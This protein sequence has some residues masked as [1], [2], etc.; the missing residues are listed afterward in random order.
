MNPAGTIIIADC[1]WTN[2]GDRIGVSS[3]F[4]KNIEWAKHQDPVIWSRVFV[5]AGFRLLDI[6]WSPLQP[7]TNI[8]ANRFVQYL[9]CLHFVLRLNA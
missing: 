9:T 6:C 1:G 4:S 7:F 5:S 3:S 8:T 2:F